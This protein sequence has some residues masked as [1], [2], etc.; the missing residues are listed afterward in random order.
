MHDFL[1]QDCRAFLPKLPS[2]SIFFMK[3]VIKAEKDVS[4]PHHPP[5]PFT[6]FPCLPNELAG[7]C[8]NLSQLK[9]EKVRDA[10]VRWR[11]CIANLP[12]VHH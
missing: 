11:V 10:T 4:T 5:S 12:L 2:T 9:S 1:V 3:A 6:S 7:V 8:S